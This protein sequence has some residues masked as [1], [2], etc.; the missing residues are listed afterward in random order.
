MAP[1]DRPPARHL[2]FLAAAEARRAGLF[3]VVRGAEARAPGMPRV[4]L[5][6]R[7]DQNIVD[8][9]QMPSLAFPSST[10]DAP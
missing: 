7:P 1:A 10:L 9:A 4:G 2:A 5:S 3:P 8:L 6:R